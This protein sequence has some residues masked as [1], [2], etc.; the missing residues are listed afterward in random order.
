MQKSSLFFAT[1]LCAF[2]SLGAQAFQSETTSV[3]PPD[4]DPAVWGRAHHPYIATVMVSGTSGPS[5]NTG[6]TNSSRELLEFRD[7]AGRVRS[8]SFY[9]SGRLMA[10]T[11]RDPAKQTMVICMP[12]PKQA[13]VLHGLAAGY[14]SPGAYVPPGAGWVVEALPPKMLAGILKVPGQR[15]TRTFTVN[16][17]TGTQVVEDWTAADLGIVLEHKAT[18]SL[19]GT[20][21]SLRVTHLVLSNPDASLF[22]IPAEYK[23]RDPQQASH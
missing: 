23:V 4:R 22:E 6:Q 2:T 1:L 18:D 5:A 9:D 10:S 12:V 11:V 13:T 20:S 7:E 3:V 8:D 19:H 17:K 21:E 16:G 14:V 15:F